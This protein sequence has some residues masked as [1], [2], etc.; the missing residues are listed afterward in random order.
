[1]DITHYGETF[2]VNILTILVFLDEKDI[3]LKKEIIEEVH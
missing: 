2:K 3:N 1:M